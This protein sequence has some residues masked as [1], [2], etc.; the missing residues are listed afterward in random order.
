MP[1]VIT[2][3]TSAEQ[4]QFLSKALHDEV[5]PEGIRDLGKYAIFGPLNEVFPQEGSHW[6][7]LAGVR[8][9]DC[10]AFKMEHAGVRAEVVLISDG[11]GFRI[12]R[13]NNVKQMAGGA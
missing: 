6:A 3:Q 1:Q 9:E 12:V 13:C 4:T 8:P 7:T 10:V 2:G 5:S 11:H